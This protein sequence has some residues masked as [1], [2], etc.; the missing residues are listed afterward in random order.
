MAVQ[1]IFEKKWIEKL[2][3]RYEDWMLRDYDKG[4][5]L[6]NSDVNL[7]HVKAQIENLLGPKE[8]EEFESLDSNKML[9]VMKKILNGPLFSTKEGRKLLD[10]IHDILDLYSKRKDTPPYGDLD[11]Y[12]VY[13][14]KLFRQEVIK[15][16]KESAKIKQ[17]VVQAI[18]RISV[19]G[20]PVFINRLLSDKSEWSDILSVGIGQ[21]HISFTIF[22]DKENVVVDDILEG[23]D[24]DFFKDP[25]ATRDYFNLVKELQHP[26]STSQGKRMILYTARPV[27]DRAIYLRGISV[28]SNI[29]LA[30]RL[31]HVMGLA[32]DLG[33]PRDIW[34]VI[35]DSKYLVET[36]GAHGMGVGYYQTVGDGPIPVFKIEPIN[37]YGED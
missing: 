30:N 26:G 23:G 21:K 16:H 25:I 6:L 33:G 2:Q 37:L 8:A 18:K 27:K 10:N 29:F 28:P 32:E 1:I 7:K 11:A 4:L 20:S 9:G 22:V 3:D 34:K 36:L 17:I 31:D 15:K 13:W 19:W 35:I 14:A 24:S 12:K 5:R